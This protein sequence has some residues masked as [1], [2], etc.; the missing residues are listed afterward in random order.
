MGDTQKVDRIVIAI[1]DGS[2]ARDLLGALNAEDFHATLIN[3]SG[4]LLHEALVTLLVGLEAGR[5]PRLMELIQLYCPSRTYYVPMGVD[6]SI[7][8]GYPSMIE[9]RIGGATLFILQVERFVQL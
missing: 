4:G 8:P 3:S 2:Q 9:A 1:L 5:L 7:M 6:S